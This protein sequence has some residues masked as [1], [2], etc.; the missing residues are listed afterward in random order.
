MV[1]CQYIDLSPGLV[2]DKGELIE[3]LFSDGLHPNARGYEVVA[4]NLEK[5]VKETTK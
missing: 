1:N 3:T 2:D 5:Y 4:R